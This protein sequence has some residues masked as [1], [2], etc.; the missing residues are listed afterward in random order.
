MNKLSPIFGN[1]SL[2]LF[3]T[4]FLGIMSMLVN[5]IIARELNVTLYGQYSIFIGVGSIMG[6]FMEG[7]AKHLIQRNISINNRLKENNIIFSSLILVSTKN[8]CFIFIFTSI[9]SFIYL[10]HIFFEVVLMC[11]CFSLTSLYQM[12]SYYLKGQQ[13]FIID[14]YFNIFNRFVKVTICAF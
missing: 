3:V 12:F 5:I 2:V 11:I 8:I 7:G 10:N 9:I 14:S 4:G 1:A 6:I 13:K